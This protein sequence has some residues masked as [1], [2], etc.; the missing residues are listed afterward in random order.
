[1]N[2]SHK[3]KRNLIEGHPALI[4]IDI[5][6]ETYYDR[7]DEAISSMPGYA[8]RTDAEAVSPEQVTIPVIKLNRRPGYG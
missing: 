4:V 7:T 6:A 2:Q 8:D 5:Q 3:T 1:M